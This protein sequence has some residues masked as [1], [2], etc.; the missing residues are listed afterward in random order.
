MQAKAVQFEAF[1]GKS[2][3]LLR[4]KKLKTQLIDLTPSGDA[5]SIQA[6]RLFCSQQEP[7]FDRRYKSSSCGDK[8]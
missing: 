3:E 6:N 8:Q 4:I 7:E 5:P 1:V 2:A